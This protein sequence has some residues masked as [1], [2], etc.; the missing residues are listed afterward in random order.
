[1]NTKTE[2]KF[3]ISELGP[4][5]P[6]YKVAD[7]LWGQGA[8]IDSDGNSTNPEDTNWTEL[9][10]CF[11]DDESPYV[12]VDPI[13]E[14]PLILEVRSTSYELAKKAAEFIANETGGILKNTCA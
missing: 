12:H 3:V 8:N 5:P 10:V 4:R 2:S 14:N 1:M 6:Y 11:R 13:S 7:Y 9:S